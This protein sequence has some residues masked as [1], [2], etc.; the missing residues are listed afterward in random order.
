MRFATSM[1]SAT[2]ETREASGTSSPWS[3]PGQPCPESG[4]VDDRALLFVEPHSLRQ[5]QGDQ[6]LPQHVL[7]RLPE[8]EVYAERERG[9]QLRQPNLRAIDLAGHSCPILTEPLLGPG[10]LNAEDAREVAVALRLDLLDLGFLAVV[11]DDAR[12]ELFEQTTEPPRGGVGDEDASVAE[13]YSRRCGGRAPGTVRT[14]H[15]RDE[16]VHRGRRA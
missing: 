9:N 7:H 6:A 10:D 12:D 3:S 5:P 16:P 2:C 4:V 11:Q 14:H 1:N 13:P 15:R 8:A